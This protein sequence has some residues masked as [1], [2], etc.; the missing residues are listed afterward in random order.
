MKWKNMN[1]S[2]NTHVVN[3]LDDNNTETDIVLKAS[4]L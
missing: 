3:Y 2:L 4:A 1:S